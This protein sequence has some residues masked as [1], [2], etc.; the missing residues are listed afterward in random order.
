MKKY[1]VYLF[2]CL[3]YLSF[4]QVERK[5]IPSSSNN[6]KT[7]QWQVPQKMFVEGIG[8]LDFI[9]FDKAN[10]D[11]VNHYLPIYFETIKLPLSASSAEIKIINPVFESLSENE[12]TILNSYSSDNLIYIKENIFPEV[13]ISYFKKNPYVNVQFIPIR[14]NNVTGKLEKLISF[15][16]QTEPIINP[17]WKKTWQS[18]R[19]YASESVLAVGNWYKIA[20]T[21]DGIYKLD[22]SFFQSI[23]IDN[24]SINPKNIRIYGNGGGQLPFANSS[25]RY[26]DLQENAIMV[27]G[28]ND[29]KF[30]TTD[31]VLFYGQS[32]H[33][34]K[35]NN[36]DQKFHHHL[37]IYSDTT[38]Y[39]IT[40]DLG[41]G[42]RIATQSSSSLTANTIISS[43]DDFMFH[44]LEAK[45]FLKSGRTWFGETFDILT[46]YSFP[47]NFP[48]I[49]PFS[50]AY[51]KVTMA[52][53]KDKTAANFSISTG[54]TASIFSCNG[55]ETS[56]IYG[57]YYSTCWDSILFFP[58]SDN[59]IV[60][61]TKQ[62]PLPAIGWL[63]YIEVNV[64]RA[65]SM[66]GSQMIFRDIKSVAPGNVSQFI[67]SNTFSSLKIWEVT[68]PINVKLQATT[69]NGTNAEFILP[70]DS[71][72]EF[73]AFNEQSFLTPKKSGRVLNQN[74]H[75]IPQ[76]DFVIVVHPL[77]LN[78]ANSLAA[79]HRTKDGLTVAVVTTEQIFNEFSSGAQDVSAIRDFAKMFYDRAADS[80]KLP[81]YLLLFGD[82]SYNLKSTVN[83]TNFIPA[84]ESGNSSDPMSSYVSDDFFGM[85][86]DTEGDWDV[87][88]G[89]LDIGIGRLP[90]KTPGEAEAAVNK[91]IRYTSVPGIIETENS[92]SSEACYGLGDWI[93]T[94]CFAAD[95]EDGSAHLTQA[96]AIAKKADALHHQSNIN[97]IYLDAYHQVSTPGGERYPD[98]TAAL[99]RQ[100]D[101]GAL[102]VNY[103]GHGG[104][105]GWAHERFLETYHIN[106][107]K[108]KCRLP[109]FFTAT[110][111]FSRW[112]NPALTSAGELT[113]L[114]A[115]G[116]AIGLI[117]TTRTVQGS[118]NFTLNNYFYDYVFKPL[119]NGEKPRMGDLNMLTNNSVPPCDLNHR[120]FSFLGDPALALSYPRYNVVTTEINGK[121][122][123]V[124]DTINALSL[125][126]IRGEV[127][128]SSGNLLS[129][130]NGILFPAV[131]DKPAKI[132][133][134]SNDANSP[135]VIFTL[136]KNILF[137]GK[138]NVTNGQFTFSFIVPKDI[139][140][141]F[142][143]G[144]ISY[145]AH[146]GFQDAS[147]YFEDF[148]IGGINA[149]A[150]QD[151]TG[152]DIKL[153]INDDKF[154]FGGMTNS[155]PKIY[156]VLNDS[157]GINI[158]GSGI[159]HDITAVLDGNNTMPI[160]M[161]DYYESDMNS[162]KKGSIRYPL[163]D[164]NEGTHTLLVKAWDVYNNS[165]S[166]YTE[167][168]VSE[169][170][171]L[172][173]SHVLNYPNPFTTKTS[174]Y[175]EHNKCCEYM[176]VDLQI[177]TVAGKKVKSIH[178][179][180]NMNGYRSNP[181]EWDGTDD[182]GD[183]I[184][185][186]IYIYRIRVKTSS[187]EI[188][189]QFEKLVILK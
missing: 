180:V 95:D 67:I 97:K 189:E 122:I 158:A 178:Q 27:F 48:N 80:T 11:I 73:I 175:F 22:Y 92:C 161:N 156:V 81:R 182:F 186:G 37:N 19:I 183:R 7:I 137:K 170:A 106:S 58:T 83:N 88:C 54:N 8:T 131:Y 9:F 139:T 90:V 135:P 168:V 169:S 6:E 105:L 138:V 78:Q 39:F 173:L 72:R 84:Y 53:R 121:T 5:Y 118:A 151:V 55:V 52:A 126:T 174:F 114:N 187:G 10:F 103:T 31:Y 35:Y 68:D 157:N 82:G 23:G 116:G 102:I 120:C 149:A 14:K 104:E 164:L 163:S 153:Y 141:N 65:M 77:F 176:D 99:M 154:V 17:E 21:S 123:N 184:G 179:L 115:E 20:V 56:N 113:F 167:F 119:P 101:K 75:S 15:N 87:V 185:R 32:Q 40:T 117:T 1:I 16:L 62:T 12:I 147:G 127:R 142:G 66:S 165:S 177:Y 85:L 159:G 112:D 50:K 152:P 89:R 94:I 2:V 74:L 132:T 130:F 148:I 93:N 38:F 140:Y 69:L 144:K 46:S 4:A 33:R 44:E 162:Y 49:D 24:A 124:P 128:D 146:N 160:V 63:N 134:L 172:A 26:D 70:T 28:E 41:A 96:D 45:N 59:V 79:L 109:F 110:C 188:A 125:V 98:A 133:T 64:R 155:D 100:M 71:L 18:N 143:K 60:N 29:S 171:Q 181:I 150:A 47:F 43:F 13:S 86:D 51:I 107:W 76:T 136:Q 57:P 25:F 91:I 34:W 166:S 3:E 36:T 61:I 111:S 129:N 108:N 42:K 30:D 145:Y